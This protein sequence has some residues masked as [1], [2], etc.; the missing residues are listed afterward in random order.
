MRPTNVLSS[1]NFMKS[2]GLTV[3]PSSPSPSPQKQ[4]AKVFI[5]EEKTSTL[6]EFDP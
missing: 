6:E 2:Q 3:K 4:K 1:D 5:K